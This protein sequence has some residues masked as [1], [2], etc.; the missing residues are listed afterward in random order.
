MS[1]DLR[2]PWLTYED[3]ALPIPGKDD[4]GHVI[5]NCWVHLRRRQMYGTQSRD[6]SASI[7]AAVLDAVHRKTPEIRSLARELSQQQE[8]IQRQEAT[9][10]RL[11]A[12]LQPRAQP[13]AHERL[14]E[15]SAEVRDKAQ[16]VF[17]EHSRQIQISVADES[18]AD[19]ESRHCLMVEVLPNE[20]AKANQLFKSESALHQFLVERLS[21]YELKAVVLTVQY[22]D[23]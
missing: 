23:D 8:M 17:S 1:V 7:R 22:T 11:L 5:E 9:I 21:S 18:D 16:E 15:I 14:A 19:F 13:I 10:D 4:P 2:M 12:M 6:V 20:T 3:V